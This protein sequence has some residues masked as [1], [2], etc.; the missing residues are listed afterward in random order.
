MTGVLK[1]ALTLAIFANLPNEFRLAVL[2]EF[3]QSPWWST[4]K[5]TLLS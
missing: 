3:V 2:L 4:A 5:V 1:N